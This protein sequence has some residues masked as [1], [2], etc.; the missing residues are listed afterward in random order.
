MTTGE[1]HIDGSAAKP[2]PKTGLVRWISVVTL[3]CGLGLLLV[4][5]V[6]AMRVVPGKV[7]GV[8]VSYRPRA[9]ENPFNLSDDSVEKELTQVIQSQLTAFRNDDYP[10]AY[11]FAATPL[12]AQV[13][14]PAF[15]RMVRN[16]YPLIAH[17][18]SAQF[19]VVLDNGHLAVVNA[20]I[21]GASGRARHY[22][23]ILQRERT[24]WKISG[25]TEVHPS[26]TTI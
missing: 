1:N 25:V 4:F 7:Q 9:S 20:T 16:G 12:K 19:G 10:Q 8:R 3:G 22:Q 6:L 24:G 11:G 14:L 5:V 13:P 2:R 21:S 18:R 26:G 15:E 17:S 23:Y